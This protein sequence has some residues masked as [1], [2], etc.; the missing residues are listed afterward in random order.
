MEILF[1]VASSMGLCLSCSREI[2]M[3]MMRWWESKA[4]VYPVMSMQHFC[5]KITIY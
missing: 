2:N 4:P 3:M 1:M 5:Q